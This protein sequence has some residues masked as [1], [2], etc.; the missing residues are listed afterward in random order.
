MSTET[1]QDL[2]V[3]PAPHITGPMSKNRLMQ[4]TFIALLIIT[5]VSAILWWPVTS[6]TSAQISSFKL[7]N[8]WQMPLGLIVLI[9]ALIAV[10][11]AVGLDALLHVLVSD[12]KLNL[13]SAAVFGLIVTLS[14]S[15]GVPAMAQASDPMP[16]GFLTAPM[17]FVYI[18]SISLVGLVIF[19]KLQGVAGRKF[20]NPAAAAQFIVLLPFISTILLAKDHF[21]SLTAGGLGVPLLA[22]P[23]GLGTAPNFAAIHGNGALS[24]GSYLLSC[25]ANPT[26]AAPSLTNVNLFSLMFLSKFH[27]W[28][29][30]ASSLAVIIVGV[31]L[32]VAA[33]K[34]VKWRIT[35]TY[36]VAIVAMSMI[37]SVAYA[38]SDM[39]TRLLFELFIGSSIFLAFFMAT[40]PASTPLTG[41]GQIIFG[42]GLAILTVLIQTYMNFFGGSLL[43]L[44]IMNLTVPLLDRVGI[45]KPFGR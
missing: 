27:G 4:Y 5:V 45:H 11:V 31:G 2:V 44:L 39:L 37:M 14:Y 21:A 9:N 23:I 22:G 32:F 12:S 38:D 30:G 35:L 3:K 10:G 20:V 17:A 7:T 18:A 43:A 1:P 13:W 36:L 24:F 41:T 42:V 8:V 28:T 33:R 26:A 6:P 40:D 34:Y 19:K 29:G 15:L 16:V 25:F